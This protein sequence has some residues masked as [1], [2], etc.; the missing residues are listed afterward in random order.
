MQ[1]HLHDLVGNKVPHHLQDKPNSRVSSSFSKPTLINGTC[2]H[3]KIKIND[4][5]NHSWKIPTNNINDDDSLETNMSEEF[6]YPSFSGGFYATYY[7]P[8]MIDR[9]RTMPR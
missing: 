5:N 2:R 8:H 1:H 6:L 7:V 9:K 4:I 3:S